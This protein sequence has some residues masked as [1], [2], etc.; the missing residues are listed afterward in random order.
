M[1]D[2]E[3]HVIWTNARFEE[4]VHKDKGYRKS[5]T[6]LFPSITREKLPLEE[7]GVAFDLTYEDSNY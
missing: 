1:L 5:I 6:S 2:E 7:Q 3:G 4:I